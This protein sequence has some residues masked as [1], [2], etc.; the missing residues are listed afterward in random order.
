MKIRVFIALIQVCL[1]STLTNCSS[2]IPQK[3]SNK[4]VELFI[5]LEKQITKLDTVIKS[6]KYIVEPL[7]R[8]LYQMNDTTSL[9]YIEGRT[10]IGKAKSVFTELDKYKQ[11]MLLH[12]KRIAAIN[13]LARDKVKFPRVD[14]E[15]IL[16]EIEAIASN[17]GAIT[18][19]TTKSIEKA[20]RVTKSIQLVKM[21]SDF[22]LDRVI[23]QKYF[24]NSGSILAKQDNIHILRTFT[25]AIDQQLD[26]LKRIFPDK[27]I[28]VEIV[29]VGYAD[30][31]P[32]RLASHSKLYQQLCQKVLPPCTNTKLNRVLSAE[33]AKALIKAINYQTKH[34][35]VKVKNI[36]K[37]KGEE[38]P[39]LNVQYAP[40]YRSGVY[41]GSDPKRRICKLS[42]FIKI[43]AY[44]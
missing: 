23:P 43:E 8:K 25:N 24:F 19:K 38:K 27:Y 40:E 3:S 39:Y 42:A 14:R 9:I 17:A 7:E 31:Q 4:A 12:R 44:K 16:K 35:L 37:G 1:L 26:T 29:V 10:E 20:T 18:I 34:K 5:T 41:S 32:I 22:Y 36:I 2:R 30:T 11:T 21:N 28:T 33:R 15:R 6:F 13:Q